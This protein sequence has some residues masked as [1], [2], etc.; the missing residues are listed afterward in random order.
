[1]KFTIK[2]L[3]K[4]LLCSTLIVGTSCSDFLTE[5]DPSNI[6][7]E[8]FF[9]VPE[10]A[11]VAVYGIYENLRFHGDGAGIFVSNFQMLDALSGTSLTETGHGLPTFSHSQVESKGW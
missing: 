4:V 10:D 3:S 7:P 1:M 5:K 8:T 2:D 9:L 11:E 6:A